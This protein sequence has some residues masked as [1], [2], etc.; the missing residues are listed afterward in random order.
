[1]NADLVQLR[2]V[3]V[4]AAYDESFGHLADIEILDACSRVICRPRS[5]PDSFSLHAPLELI[6]R[7]LVAALAAPSVRRYARI[8]MLK[9]ATRYVEGGEILR[10]PRDEHRASTAALQTAIARGDVEAADAHCEAL[11]REL[12]DG[13]L[14]HLFSP[15]IEASLAAAG[16]GPILLSLIG[17]LPAGSSRQVQ[18]LTRNLARALASNPQQRITWYDELRR[19]GRPGAVP[20]DPAATMEAAINETSFA[21]EEPPGGIYAVV[22]SAEECGELAR[23]LGFL[24]DLDMDDAHV[25]TAVGNAL[26]RMAAVG[27][28]EEPEQHAKYGWTHCLTLPQAAWMLVHEGGNPSRCMAL[29]ASFVVALRRGVG[30]VAWDMPTTKPATFDSRALLAALNESPKAAVATAL[31][32]GAHDINETFRLL[33]TAA[34][35]RTDAHLIKYTLACFDA[36]RSDQQHA[37]IYAAAAAKLNAIWMRDEPVTLTEAQKT[38]GRDG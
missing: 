1:M 9:I 23:R 29:A 34:S 16:H 8:N 6:A 24:A 38:V 35:V 20:A 11:C 2:T 13:S 17:R 19:A 14:R 18:H 30:R 25:R 31:A 37:A 33:A 22:H 21:A 7:F 28:L 12:D 5:N 32:V 4:E 36:A 26:C 15:L 27:M 10:E 3:A